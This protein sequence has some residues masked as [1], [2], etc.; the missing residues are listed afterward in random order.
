MIGEAV[1]RHLDGA[2]DAYEELLRQLPERQRNV[3]HAVSRL[4]QL[5]ID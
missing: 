5:K 1:S 3:F 4:F 2:G